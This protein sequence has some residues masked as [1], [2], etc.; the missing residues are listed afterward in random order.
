MKK[1]I[2]FGAFDEL[3]EQY[4][5]IIK[6]AKEYGDYLVVVIALDKTISSLGNKQPKHNQDQRMKQVMELGLADKVRLGYLD[7][8]YRAIREEIPDIVALGFDQKVFV[9]D[10]SDN[11]PETT[12]IVRLSP[13][14]TEIFK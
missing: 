9:D 10:L 6:E 5:H 13:H 2:I 3:L 7:D 4:V 14:K 1:V 11:I 12:R 8:P